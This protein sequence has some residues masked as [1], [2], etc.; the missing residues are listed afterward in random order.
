MEGTPAPDLRRGD[1]SLPCCWRR[2]LLSRLQRSAPHLPV[3]VP[4]PTGEPAWPKRWRLCGRRAQAGSRPDHARHWRTYGG[5]GCV[6][7][8]PDERHRHG[9]HDQDRRARH[10][11]KTICPAPDQPSRGQKRTEQQHLRVIVHCYAFWFSWGGKERFVCRNN[12]LECQA[13]LTLCRDPLT[14]SR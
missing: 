4:R 11:P 12:L 1:L 5:C 10:R 8:H 13:S 14:M 6:G 2:W 9:S 3:P 7:A